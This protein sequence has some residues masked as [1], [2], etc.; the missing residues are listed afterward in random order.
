MTLGLYWSSLLNYF[1]CFEVLG[2]MGRRLLNWTLDDS[3]RFDC[4]LITMMTL[5]LVFELASAGT[6]VSSF[7]SSSV[8]LEL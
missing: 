6:M 1:E 5:G 4:A 7:L 2:L 3:D 8:E